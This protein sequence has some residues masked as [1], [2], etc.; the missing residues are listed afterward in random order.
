MNRSDSVDETGVLSFND[1]PAKAQHVI[2]N[3]MMKSVSSNSV[4]LF[5]TLPA[6]AIGTCKSEQESREYVD[7]LH[8]WLQDLPPT[9]LLNSQ[10]MTVTTA[11]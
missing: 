2:L 10:V 1:L 9:I 8:L 7:S 6:P 3:D 5:S 11:L 4:I